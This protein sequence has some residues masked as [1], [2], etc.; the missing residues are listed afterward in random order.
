MCTFCTPDAEGAPRKGVRC[1]ENRMCTSHFLG[2][3]KAQ[4]AKARGRELFAPR[5]DAAAGHRA[6]GG[7]PQ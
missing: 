6:D 5:S 7:A 4:L 1:A 3:R 2:G